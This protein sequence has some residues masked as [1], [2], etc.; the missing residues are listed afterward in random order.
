MATGASIVGTIE[1][2]ELQAD[3][4]QRLDQAVL[5]YVSPEMSDLLQSLHNVAGALQRHGRVPAV[6]DWIEEYRTITATG[7]G[8][9]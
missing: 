2:E 4:I 9:A 3:E 5:F 8:R 6:A 1:S 7:G